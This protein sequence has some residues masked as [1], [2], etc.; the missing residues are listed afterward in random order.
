MLLSILVLLII[1]TL[2]LI[3]LT[4][5]EVM[6]LTAILTANREEECHNSKQLSD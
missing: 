1:I 4:F 5:I 6:A 3:F 2:L